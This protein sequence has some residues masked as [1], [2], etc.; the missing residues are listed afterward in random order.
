MAKFEP[1]LYLRLIG[2]EILLDAAP[3]RGGWSS[4]LQAA[5][6]ALVAIGAISESKARSV[7]ADYDLAQALRNR[8]GYHPAMRAALHAKRGKARA[9][10]FKR[11]AALNTA[12]EDSQGRL[13][14]R[15][16][17]FGDDSIALACTYR[18]RSDQLQARRRRGRRMTTY[19]YGPGQL[20][21]GS[22]APTLSDD[23]GNSATLQ[24]GGSGSELEW[25]GRLSADVPL[26]PA[27][28]WLQY[29]GHR[30]ELDPADPTVEVSVEELTADGAVDRY[31]W[32]CLAV[33]ERHGPP[34]I[35]PALEALIAAGA[36]APEDPVIGELRSVRERLPQHPHDNPG[37][38]GIRGLPQPWR[39]LLA[40]A[41]K[42]DGPTGRIV[43]GARTPLF[44]GY[45]VGILSLECEASGFCVEVETTPASVQHP[46]FGA[47]AG[48][49]LAWWARDDKGNHYLGSVGSWSGGGDSC[50][51][52]INF[53]PALDPR[54]RR[55][56]LCPTTIKA[57]AVIG[58]ELH[59]SEPSVPS[60]SG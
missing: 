46:M 27:T 53:W 51:A 35:D 43:L 6:N 60:E 10:S 23:R 56:E 4:P 5:A 38:R 13:E 7:A 34:S 33:G 3:D 30:L 12:I 55:L 36:L 41:G 29:D 14:L 39:S 47:L 20:P 54:A 24:F 59:W 50:T 44:D 25:T 11:V 18:T 15:F 31:L 40:R 37:T 45:R 26:A 22:P 32:Q 17:T 9:L 58:F 16:A 1:E 8:G 52:E 19:G 42:D 2:E 21:W 28:R 49:Q 48:G 57:R